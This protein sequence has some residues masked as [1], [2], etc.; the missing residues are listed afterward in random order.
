MDDF[1]K[2][3]YEEY[4]EESAKYRKQITA[5]NY[6]IGALEYHVKFLANLTKDFGFDWMKKLADQS[7]E[8]IA[9]L[10]DR[11]KKFIEE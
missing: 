1:Y 3:R 2:R 4:L 6:E 7:L 9:T 11:T 10:S 5:L 8:D